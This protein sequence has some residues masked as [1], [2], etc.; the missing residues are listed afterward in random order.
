MEKTDEKSMK[1]RFTQRQTV[2]FFRFY[3]WSLWGGMKRREKRSGKNHSGRKLNGNEHR[4]RKTGKTV[5][6]NC[7][8]GLSERKR[9]T[10]RL[11]C[12]RYGK[13]SYNTTTGTAVK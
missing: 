9:Q 12:Y 1:N 13:H 6:V 10:I 11:N 2:F 4:P 7:E 8:Y 5:D 3:I